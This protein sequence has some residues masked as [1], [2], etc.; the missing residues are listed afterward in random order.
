MVVGSASSTILFQI[1]WL[2]GNASD[3]NELYAIACLSFFCLTV[4]TVYDLWILRKKGGVCL[5][6]DQYEIYRSPIIYQHFPQK[7]IC[8][9]SIHGRCVS[10]TCIDGSKVNVKM[11]FDIEMAGPQ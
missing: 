1:K 9:V 6:D 10:L 8:A 7:D 11:P 5:S 2:L 3:P 4:L